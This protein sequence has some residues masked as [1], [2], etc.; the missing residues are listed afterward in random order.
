MHNTRQNTD[1]ER[2]CPVQRACN[3]RATTGFEE[4]RAAFSAR[5][6]LLVQAKVRNWVADFKDLANKMAL[7]AINNPTG[8][9]EPWRKLKPQLICM[10]YEYVDIHFL[11]NGTVQELKKGKDIEQRFAREV[12]KQIKRQ[13]KYRNCEHKEILQTVHH[14]EILFEIVTMYGIYPY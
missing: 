11:Y 5:L 7:T 3:E 1:N 9:V 2:S 6:K 14:S 8:T 13:A 10:Y 12:I 4:R